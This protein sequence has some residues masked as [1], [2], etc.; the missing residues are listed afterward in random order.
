VPIS[1]SKFRL[2]R[3][4]TVVA[5]SRLAVPL[6]PTGCEMHM[7]DSDFAQPWRDPTPI[8]FRLAEQDACSASEA[9]VESRRERRRM[10][11][12]VGFVHLR[13]FGA[14]ADLIRVGEPTFAW[15]ASR[16]SRS[17]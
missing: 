8:T 14:T 15:L 4:W 9:R 1:L 3:I 13:A 7:R 12:R 5:L 10:A 6:R 17:R 11:E 2:S 16:S